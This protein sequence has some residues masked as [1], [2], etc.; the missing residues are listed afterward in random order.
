[1]AETELPTA[2]V[3]VAH[4]ARSIAQTPDDQLAEGMRSEFRAAILDE[5]FKRM[6]EHFD[7]SRAADV[8][9]VIHWEITGGPDGAVDRYEVV[10]RNASCHAS[11]AINESSRVKFTIDGVQFLKLVTGNASG[12]GLFVQGKLKVGGDLMFAARVAG[13][14]AIPK[15]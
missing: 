2:G 8:D 9:A 6:E 14:F 13:L 10:I 12:P 4:F 11:R 15:F 1:M 5:I 7:P 3:D